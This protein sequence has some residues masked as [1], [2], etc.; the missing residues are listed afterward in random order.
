M[1]VLLILVSIS[2]RYAR[3][4]HIG[5]KKNKIQKREKVF[6]RLF[7]FSSTVS[8]PPTSIP[9]STVE[10]SRDWIEMN[11]NNTVVNGQFNINSM[12]VPEK[13]MLIIFFPLSFSVLLLLGLLLSISNER[14]G[15]RLKI[16]KNFL[17]CF[18]HIPFFFISY[19]FEVPVI[20]Y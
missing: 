20:K 18:N 19:R 14:V 7:S 3:L 10:N 17:F 8:T 12:H 15:N 13:S 11:G 5:Y 1:M 2:V 6:Y 9:A 4:I 16:E